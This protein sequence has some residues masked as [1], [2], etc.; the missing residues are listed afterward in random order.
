VLIDPVRLL[1]Y[2]LPRVRE[3]RVG[4]LMFRELR[5]KGRVR[6]GVRVRVRV[7]VR[8][9]V[10]VRVRVRVG[11]KVRIRVIRVRLL[12]ILPSILQPSSS[13]R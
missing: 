10:R 2:I 13:S 8:V 1:L 6:V 3:L 9:G 5:V 11:V 4:E 7:R 12:Y